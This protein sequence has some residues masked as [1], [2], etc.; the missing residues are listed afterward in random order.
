MF[1]FEEAIDDGG[2]VLV[3]FGRHD[4]SQCLSLESK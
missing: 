1:L 3:G 4:F 2:D